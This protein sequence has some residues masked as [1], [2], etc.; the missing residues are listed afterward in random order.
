MRAKLFLDFRDT[1]I[2]R[3]ALAGCTVPQIRA[4]TGH[5]MQT[6]HQVLEHYL[7]IDDRM[8][9]AGITRLKTWMADEGIA[10]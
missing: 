9:A 1:A 6:I 5:Q 8:A 10:L 3:L 2:T 4:I 7:A